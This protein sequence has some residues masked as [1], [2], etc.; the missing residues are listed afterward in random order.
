MMG[1]LQSGRGL[2]TACGCY[3][4]ARCAGEPARFLIPWDFPFPGQPWTRHTYMYVTSRLHCILNIPPLHHLQ[5]LV[6][7]RVTA[8]YSMRALVRST[9]HSLQIVRGS[10]PLLGMAAPCPPPPP[11]FKPTLSFFSLSRPAI[12]QIRDASME[13]MMGELQKCQEAS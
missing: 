9:I 1:R 6:E 5:L 11:S 10:Q 13:G 12:G 2:H 3:H 8:A 4:T 7:R